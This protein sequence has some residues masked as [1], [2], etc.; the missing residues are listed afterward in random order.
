MPPADQ[1]SS[2]R[3]GGGSCHH[4]RVSDFL[5]AHR[6]YRPCRYR[7][8][9]D[10]FTSK[11]DE[12]DL[13]PDPFRMNHHDPAHI[14][15]LQTLFRQAF[16]KNNRIQFLNHHA[17][18]GTVSVSSH[19]PT[20]TRFARMRGLRLSGALKRP[21]RIYFFP[22][23]VSLTETTRAERACASNASR[24]LCHSA[25]RNPNPIKKAALARPAGCPPASR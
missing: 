21:S 22:N 2:T 8:D 24:N 25:V 1:P 19:R 5:S 7:Y 4:T 10:G 20:R 14:T 13:V 9:G 16:G 6:A 23:S 12:L 18:P 3:G 11:G 15:G 17:T